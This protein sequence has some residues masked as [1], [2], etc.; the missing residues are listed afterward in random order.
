MSI[1]DI[2][3][4]AEVLLSQNG[5]QFSRVSRVLLQSDDKGSIRIKASTKRELLALN[6]IG[7]NSN[8]L[9]ADHILL[10]MPAK[11]K[12]NEIE[13]YLIPAKKANEAMVRDHTEWANQKPGR[14]KWLEPKYNGLEE[15]SFGRLFFNRPETAKEFEEYRLPKTV[16]LPQATAEAP[17]LVEGQEV[18]QGQAQGDSGDVLD[19]AKALIAR[20]LGIPLEKVQLEVKI[21]G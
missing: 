2:R 9:G 17:P 11:Y 4:A 8:L 6:P 1:K 7:E 18:P 15:N 10:V 21:N 19:E 13:G 20:R 5:V 14:K 12:P 16:P 3:N